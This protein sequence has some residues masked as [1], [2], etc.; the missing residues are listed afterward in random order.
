[1]MYGL[2][3]AVCIMLMVAIASVMIITM[4]WETIPCDRTP[5]W[6]DDAYYKIY[7]IIEKVLT[8]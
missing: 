6:L 4:A 2:F 1:M 3:V 8:R 5:E 7:E